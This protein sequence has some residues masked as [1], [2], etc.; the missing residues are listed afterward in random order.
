MSSFTR[1]PDLPAELRLEIWREHFASCHGTQIHIF[2][3]TPQGPKYTN[4]DAA[5]GL[6]GYNTLAAAKV[7][8]ESWD[9]FRKSFHVGDT[10]HLQPQN[11]LRDARGR[12][13][14]YQ[15]DDD[16]EETGTSSLRA[17]YANAA[18]E[19]LRR[20]TVEFAFSPDDMFYIVDK[21]ITP[22]LVS[23][24]STPWAKHVR[25]LAMQILNFVG[26]PAIATEAAFSRVNRW[27]RWDALL[28]MPP[29][30]LRQLLA[31]P[32]LHRL[33]F[34][35]VPN[36]LV[37]QFGQ[38]RPNTYGFVV[39]DSEDFVFGSQF[40][41]YIV[42]NHSRITYTRLCEAFPELEGRIGCVVDAVPARV[43]FNVYTSVT[44]GM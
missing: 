29:E 5:S 22:L 44:Y 34:V 35:V 37:N 7:S 39:V 42:R 30:S 2:H 12:L 3:C 24:S 11:T 9:V 14:D 4:Q 32:A 38:L 8:A 1:F 33:L 27:A 15:D 28:S 43:R 40:E 25:H 41:S 6:P 21:E 31:G 19:E 20:Q 23:M 10:R 36:A 16:P 13:I 26:C 18:R 17:I